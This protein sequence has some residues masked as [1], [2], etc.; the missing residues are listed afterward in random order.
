MTI[1]KLLIATYGRSHM[2][3]ARRREEIEKDNMLE[4]YDKQN[5]EM[6]EMGY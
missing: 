1:A 4:E 5:S 6:I 2:L 3:L